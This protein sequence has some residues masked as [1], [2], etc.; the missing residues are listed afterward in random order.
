[1][2]RQARQ[3]M[4][5][6]PIYNSDIQ[7]LAGVVM[8]TTSADRCDGT[9]RFVVA[10]RSR[11]GDCHWTSPPMGD[12]TQADAAARVLAAFVGGVVR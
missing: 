9:Q 10:W 2:T 11:G 12:D 6:R 3:P 1:M 4:R 5:T 8:V 7:S